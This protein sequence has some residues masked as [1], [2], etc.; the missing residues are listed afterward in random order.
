MME[1]TNPQRGGAKRKRGQY[2][3]KLT[4]CLAM[5]N[6]KKLKMKT[7]HHPP[8]LGCHVIAELPFHC[9]LGRVATH[10]C[11][12]GELHEEKQIHRTE[13]EKVTAELKFF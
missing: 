3:G 4:P 8:R 10:V 7:T 1:C 6:K 13:E 11:D 9:A 12:A 2:S 5:K